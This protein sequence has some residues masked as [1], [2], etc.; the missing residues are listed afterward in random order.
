MQENQPAGV[1][2]FSG[3]GRPYKPL[4]K[5]DPNLKPANN[6]DARNVLTIKKRI[7]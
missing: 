7:G 1:L 5:A 2:S 4:E 3:Q 6:R